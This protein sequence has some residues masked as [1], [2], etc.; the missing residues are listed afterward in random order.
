[1]LFTGQVLIERLRRHLIGLVAAQR[2]CSSLLE[3]WSGFRWFEE[4]EEEEEGVEE[5][6]EEVKV[7]EESVGGGLQLEELLELAAELF[8]ASRESKLG[9]REGRLESGL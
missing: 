9:G 4:E 3:L 7:E 6:E 5:E 2:L 8:A 1:M